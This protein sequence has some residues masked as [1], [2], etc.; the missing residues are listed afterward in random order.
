M[1]LIYW[2]V[3]ARQSLKKNA[4]AVAYLESVMPQRVAGFHEERSVPESACVN[5]QGTDYTAILELPVHSVKLPVAAVWDRRAAVFTPCRF[6]GNLYAGTFVIGGADADGQFDFVSKV[7]IGERVTVTN[8]QGEVFRYQ[9]ADVK[10]AKNAKIETLLQDDYDLV[11]FA[12]IRKTGEVI[13][14]RCNLY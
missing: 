12:E 5:Y 3:T 14:V 2:Q 9:V 11:L 6:T 13:L 10:H 7:D 4:D 8:M 1:L